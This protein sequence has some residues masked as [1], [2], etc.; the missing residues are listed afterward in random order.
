MA[1]LTKPM[2]ASISFQPLAVIAGFFN[3]LN[4][5]H[6]AA[7]LADSLYGA[8]DAALAAKGLKRDD[9]NAHIMDELTRR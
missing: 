3:R 1:T 6:R 8:S 4:A 2:T 9:I 7:T 5:A